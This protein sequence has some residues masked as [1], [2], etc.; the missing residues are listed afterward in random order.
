MRVNQIRGA[1]FPPDET[2]SRVFD[3]SYQKQAI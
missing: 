1:G 2:L 3:L